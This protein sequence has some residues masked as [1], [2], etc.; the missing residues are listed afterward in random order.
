[1]EGYNVYE[2]VKDK[3]KETNVKVYTS[4]KFTYSEP[5]LSDVEFKSV[6]SIIKSRDHLRRNVTEITY[7][8]LRSY[9]ELSGEF[10]HVLS[11]VLDVDTSRLWEGARIYIF[12][13]LGRDSWTLGNGTQV[14]LTRI[15]QKK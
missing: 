5:F 11:I 9:K 10:R 15:H 2:S 14:R 6:D 7:G 13:N 8:T 12:N 4:V 3:L 1:M